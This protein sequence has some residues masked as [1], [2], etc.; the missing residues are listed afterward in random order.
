MDLTTTDV[1]IKWAYGPVKG[2]DIDYHSLAGQSPSTY[3]LTK[4]NTPPS[5]SPAPAPVP[6]PDDGFLFTNA[7][8]SFKAFWYVLPGG[9]SIKIQYEA[10]FKDDVKS[11]PGW[12]GFGLRKF[13]PDGSMVRAWSE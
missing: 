3:N 5:P 7:D 12:A 11:K 10:T 8:G 9:E 13:R 2:D 4:A 1:Y 6:A